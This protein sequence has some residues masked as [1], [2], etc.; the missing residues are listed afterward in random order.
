MDR[1]GLRALTALM[2]WKTALIDAPFGGAG[3]P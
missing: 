1:Q 3:D 2:T